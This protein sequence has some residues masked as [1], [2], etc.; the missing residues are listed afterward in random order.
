MVKLF[1]RWIL[2]A[3]ALMVVAE[4][5]PG[6]KVESYGAAMVS[7]LILGLANALI[8][9]VLVIITLPVT[10]LTL[11]LFALVING[12]LFWLVAS[13]VSGVSV[14]GF[15]AAFWGAIVYGVL[16]WLINLSLH[17]PQSPRD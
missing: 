11:G 6:V 5:V 13:M 3:M 4:I 2:T 12:C 17:T 10:L 9:P 1:L 7:A 16:G 14:T 8:R 15:G